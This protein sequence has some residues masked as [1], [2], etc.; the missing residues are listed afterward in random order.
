MAAVGAS[1]APDPIDSKSDMA[2]ANNLSSSLPETP[3]TTQT[4]NANPD[5]NPSLTDNSITDQNPNLSGPALT[6]IPPGVPP[7]AS[8]FRPLGAPQFSAVPNPNPNFSM[9]QG[10]VIQ[11]PGVANSSLTGSTAA[12]VP[13]QVMR[14][15]GMYQALPG[16]PPLQMHLQYGQVPNAPVPTSGAIP[17]P[18]GFL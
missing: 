16:Q 5:Q 12:P 1:P 3:S 14:P 7:F 8:S 11:P 2:G 18:G 13:S 9:G 4:S 6:P 10:T 17:P 15:V